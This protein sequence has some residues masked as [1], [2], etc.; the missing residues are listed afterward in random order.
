MTLLRVH[1]LSLVTA[2]IAG[3]AFASAAHSQTI[4]VAATVRNDVAQVKGASAVPISI[5]ENVVRNEVVRT[6][7]D[8][9]TKLVFSDSTNLAVGPVSTVTLDRFVFAGDGNYRDAT[10]NLVRGAFRF[11]T[12]SSDKRAYKINTPVATI[13][14]R[15]TELDI[16][17]ERARTVATLN[18]GLAIVC[19]RMGGKCVTLSNPGDTAVVTLGGVTRTRAGAPGFSFAQF[20]SGDGGLCAPMT[21]AFLSSPA[22]EVAALCGR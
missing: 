5:G 20:C 19:T 15:G 18:E 22:T 6:G 2:L 7:A 4:G 14:V 11:S 16:L 13:G 12:G 10:V 1:V 3:V 8:S 17:S 21:F 9:S